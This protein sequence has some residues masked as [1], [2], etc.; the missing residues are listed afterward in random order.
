MKPMHTVTKISVVSV[1]ALFAIS[2]VAV[3][4]YAEAKGISGVFS[5]SSGNNNDAP[6]TYVFDDELMMR[7]NNMKSPYEF[8]TELFDGK[9]L[10]IGRTEILNMMLFKN[11]MT[12][13]VITVDLNKSTIHESFLESTNVA[14]K[15]N[16]SIIDLIAPEIQAPPE[17]ILKPNV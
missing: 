9:R 14:E 12:Y 1:L 2:I 13:S 17:T 16:C 6:V 7:N 5:C 15:F 11:V 8:L 3:G 4:N 10:Y